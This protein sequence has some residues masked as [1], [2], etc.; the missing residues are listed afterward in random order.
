MMTVF[1]FTVLETFTKKIA[2]LVRRLM[3]LMFDHR[4]LGQDVIAELWH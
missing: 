4:N 3:C 2:S 1:S